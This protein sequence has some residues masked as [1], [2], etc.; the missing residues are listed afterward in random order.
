MHAERLWIVDVCLNNDFRG[1]IAADRKAGGLLPSSKGGAAEQ[2]KSNT[3]LVF[4]ASLRV[5]RGQKGVHP[6][7]VRKRPPPAGAAAGGP[8]PDGEGDASGDG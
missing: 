1:Q 6:P 5:L 7:E 4:S 2:R 3:S 8:L